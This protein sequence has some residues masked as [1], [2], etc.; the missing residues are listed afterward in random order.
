LSRLVAFISE[1]IF[2][3]AGRRDF[4]KDNYRET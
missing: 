3:R 4:I 1:L 2:S